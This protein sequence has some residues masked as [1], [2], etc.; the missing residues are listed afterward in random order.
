MK[1]NKVF[2]LGLITV[3]VAVLS[4]TLVSGTYAKYTSTVSG[5]SSARVA[6]WA[7]DYK[8]NSMDLSSSEIAF[9]LFETV[10]DPNVATGKNENIIAPGTSGSFE[11]TVQNKSEVTATYAIDFTET[12]S[13]NIPIEYSI[14]GTKWENDIN[15]LDIAA[16]TLAMGSDAVTKT[17]HW[18]WVFSVEGGDSADTTLGIGGTATVKVEAKITFEQVD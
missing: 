8:G 2:L 4:F 12:N 15:E 11:I 7:F 1:K 18:R 13:N 17:V 9:E 3:F 16:T 10:K 14:D 6:K 5:D